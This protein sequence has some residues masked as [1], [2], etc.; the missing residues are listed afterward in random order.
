MNIVF[1]KQ[2]GDWSDVAIWQFYNE[3]TQ[4][5]EDYG[6]VPQDG[7]NI[8]L[9]GYIINF[10]ANTVLN[11]SNSSISNEINP[12]TNKNG[13]Q[14]T[15]SYKILNL[16]F[17]NYYVGDSYL[18]VN[19]YNNSFFNGN[20]YLNG[21]GAAI[22]K[23]G[24][25]MGYTY[26]INGNVYCNNINASL[27]NDSS[28][29]GNTLTINGNIVSNVQINAVLYRAWRTVIINGNVIWNG[30]LS[31]TDETSYQPFRT[32]SLTV[33]GNLTLSGGITYVKDAIISGNLVFRNNAVLLGYNLSIASNIDYQSNNGS[34]GAC[35]ASVTTTNP[36]T[37]V[38]KDSSIIRTN[39]Y[40]IIS[41]KD[42]NDYQQ[43]P[44]EQDVRN[45]VIY[46]YGLKE[47]T[48]VPDFPQPATVL[49]C[50]TYDDGNKVGSLNIAT[51]QFIA[52][53]IGE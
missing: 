1:P 13:G 26:T 7:D 11:L 41:D 27:A 14:I 25:N 45:G 12:Y 47:G 50:V 21:S 17:K 38:W 23:S 10:S 5:V 2:N 35:F 31:S 32:M 18:F 49:E 24:S 29:Y 9:D 37:F 40:V 44:H 15:T 51:K 4:Q 52:E 42:M 19:A 20:F 46:E 28:F 39:P 34:L 8:Y 48:Y 16:T 43:L 36:D 22:Y 3:N 33:N 30:A 53:L 6:Q